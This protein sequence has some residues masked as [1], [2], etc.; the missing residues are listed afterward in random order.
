MP[1]IWN[2]FRKRLVIIYFVS[3]STFAQSNSEQNWLIALEGV[4]ETDFRTAIGK[5]MHTVKFEKFKVSGLNT[6]IYVIRNPRKYD[7]FEKFLKESKRKGLIQYFERDHVGYGSALQV[8]IPNDAG[9]DQQWYLDNDGSFD[10]R[11]SASKPGADISILSGWNITFGDTAT[12][13]AI[14]DSGIN[15]SE[16]DISSRIWTNKGE[17]PNNGIDDDHNGFIDD[18][19]GWNFVDDNNTPI[20]D[21]GHGSAIAGAIG[22]IPDNTIGISGINWKC[23][24]MIC[25]VLQSNLSGLYSNWA[26]GIYYAVDNG[27]KIINMSLN[28]DEDLFTLSDAVKYANDRG[29]IIIASMGNDNDSIK[30]FP[31]AYSSTVAVGST[32]SN[33]YRSKS[34]FTSSDFGS[35]YG[36]HIDLV[37]PGNFILSLSNNKNELKYWSGTSLSCAL[38]SGVASLIYAIKPQS[39]PSQIRDILFASSKDLVGDFTE[40]KKGWDKFYGFGRLD[41]GSAL[42][43]SFNEKFQQTSSYYLFPNPISPERRLNVEGFLP[44][45]SE[46]Q[47]VIYDLNGK[48]LLTKTILPQQRNFYAQLELDYF[49]AGLYII[50]VNHSKSR[51]VSKIAIP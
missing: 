43:M 28:G 45:L 6:A 47:I 42:E 51:Y 50:S 9:F 3:F 5:N 37:A 46:I 32:D 30:S 34:F 27:A 19:F 40:D 7:N 29:V 33:D 23:K 13:V 49:R 48:V 26:K 22:A 18:Y 36:D 1:K 14:L 41:A 21:N 44:N 39:K 4:K 15:F 16:P 12:V 11:N 10:Y 2:S 20:D 8:T 31:A 17:I 24:L 38:V 35:N 25:K